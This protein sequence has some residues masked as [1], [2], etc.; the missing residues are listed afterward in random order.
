MSLLGYRNK[1]QKTTLCFRNFFLLLTLSLVCLGNFGFSGSESFVPQAHAHTE[2]SVGSEG[3][4]TFVDVPG[5]RGSIEAVVQSCRDGV[6]RGTFL[7]A[8]LTT[9]VTCLEGKT[10]ADFSAPKKFSFLQE[11][12]LPAIREYKAQYIDRAPEGFGRG[13]FTNPQKEYIKRF[14]FTGTNLTLYNEVLYGYDQLT[15]VTELN[16]FDIGKYIN[17]L[18]GAYTSVGRT[19]DPDRVVRGF[20]PEVNFPVDDVTGNSGQ[21]WNND[22]PNVDLTAI[23]GS[24]WTTA[25]R[26]TSRSIVL[27]DQLVHRKILTAP[28]AGSTTGTGSLAAGNKWLDKFAYNAIDQLLGYYDR[29]ASGGVYFG[30]WTQLATLSHRPNYASSGIVEHSPDLNL[31][32]GPSTALEI[33]W[34]R[35]VNFVQDDGLARLTNACSP[36]IFWDA[37]SGTEDLRKF[38]Q[39]LRW[40]REYVDG[41]NTNTFHTIWEGQDHTFR[42]SAPRLQLRRHPDITAAIDRL[43]AAAENC[44]RTA[45]TTDHVGGTINAPT[46]CSVD[47]EVAGN[48]EGTR[49][50]VVANVVASRTRSPLVN[51]IFMLINV[52]LSAIIKFLLWITALVMDMFHAVLNYTGFT[53]EGFV[54]A[55]WRAIRDFVNLFFILALLII[56]VAN[57]VQYQINTYAIKTILPKFI[58]IVLAVNFSRLFTG[59]VIDAANVVEAGVYQIGGMGPHGAGNTVACSNASQTQGTF[60]F[61]IPDTIKQGSVLCRLITGLKFEQLQAY[62]SIDTSQE[63]TDQV[64]FFWVNVVLIIMLIMMFFGFLALAVT[65]VIRI[66]ILWALVIVSPLYVISKL[67]PFTSSIGSQWEGKFFKYASMQVGVAFFLTLAV[68][69]ASLISTRIFGG[70]SQIATGAVG[71]LH[72]NGFNTWS[73]YLQLGFIMAMVYAAVFTAAKSDYGN[74]I[75][76]SISKY[77]RPEAIYG[78]GKKAGGFALGLPGGIGRRMQASQNKVLRGLGGFIAAPSNYY[79]GA[80]NV[81]GEL[82]RG[83]EERKTRFGM[84]AASSLVPRKTLMGQRF[85]AQ[86]AQHEEKLSR[87]RAEFL[88][89]LDVKSIE[90]NLERGLKGKNSQEYRAS[91]QALA[92]RGALDLNKRT[93]IDGKEMTYRDAIEQLESKRLDDPGQAKEYIASLTSMSSGNF[94]KKYEEAEKFAKTN[95]DKAAVWTAANSAIDGKDSARVQGFIA[96]GFQGKMQDMDAAKDGVKIEGAASAMKLWQKAVEQGI[97]SDDARSEFGK[98]IGGNTVSTFAAMLRKKGS[99]QAI[100]QQV[101]EAGQQLGLITTDIAKYED[102]GTKGDAAKESIERVMASLTGNGMYQSSTGTKFLSESSIGVEALKKIAQNHLENVGQVKLDGDDNALTGAIQSIAPSELARAHEVN[103]SGQFEQREVMVAK[104]IRALLENKLEADHGDRGAAFDDFSTDYFNKYTENLGGSLT[105]ESKRNAMTNMLNNVMEQI[106]GAGKY[107]SDQISG[108]ETEI[109]QRLIKA[110]EEKEMAK[111]RK[112]AEEIERGRRA[113]GGT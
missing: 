71:S 64:D 81:V 107:S 89:K 57:I 15:D 4:A 113:G 32:G 60:T 45:S 95:T 23:D 75:I 18:A 6:N 73:D 55:M 34:Q 51:A 58:L 70:V 37:I 31:I 74:G 86:L 12:Y 106:K 47:E 44:M 78:Y 27:L 68:M 28:P 109:R 100:M 9:F 94:N 43:V 93:T 26:I 30:A 111:R 48:R 36:N 63:G 40:E 72:P 101:F 29:A 5:P 3:E 77:G 39:C 97:I 92:E 96:A 10:S 103:A 53:T 2:E 102:R 19:V 35:T 24:T 54:V 69:S 1:N 79:Q 99:E 8:Q 66:I 82:K 59:I 25:N 88:V 7:E 50:G 112:E 33:E 65:F 108:V 17:E 22:I 20:E 83:A 110:P 49:A 91:L 14:L 46:A 80:K 61:A 105:T 41:S 38:A 56:A 84:K 21:I 104:T 42:E 62:S 13:G 11:V 87:E 90:D 85:Q 52:L 98:N 76:D 67:F 16:R